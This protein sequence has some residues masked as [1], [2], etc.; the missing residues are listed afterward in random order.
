[1]TSRKSS[2]KFWVLLIFFSLLAAYGCTHS[3]P[4]PPNPVAQSQPQGGSPV[5]P[6][7]TGPRPQFL[8]FPD[9]PIPSELDLRAKDSYVFQAGPIKTGLLTL[10]G[11]VDINSLINFFNMAMPREN[12]KQM[13]QF[14]YRHSILI[15]GKPEKTCVIRL[16]EEAIYTYIEIYVAPTTT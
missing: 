16:W 9:I 10:R 3:S 2:R 6:P 1:M 13:G 7:A 11:R 8:D 4:P 14:R 12:W 5:I 15:F